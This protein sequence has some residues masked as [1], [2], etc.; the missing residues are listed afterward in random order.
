MMLKP[1]EDQHAVQKRAWSNA[2]PGVTFLSVHWSRLIAGAIFLVTGGLDLFFLGS[3]IGNHTGTGTAI[4]LGGP[5][6]F[7][8]IGMPIMVIGG[9]LV[10]YFLVSPIKYTFTVSA[11]ATGI[12]FQSRSKWLFF[13]GCYDL[14]A[15]SRVLYQR[16]RLGPKSAWIV[17]LVHWIILIL[18]YGAGLFYLP[19]ST[20]QI[21]PTMMMITAVCDAIALAVLIFFMPASLRVFTPGRV[22]DFWISVPPRDDKMQ[23][24][25]LDTAFPA[26]STKSPEKSFSWT[27]LIVGLF[28]IAGSLLGLFA[29]VLLG[30][31]FSMA[32][33]MYGLI[34]VLESVFFDLGHEQQILEHENGLSRFHIKH[35]RNPLSH[36]VDIATPGHEGDRSASTIAPWHYIFIA[37]L[38]GNMAIQLTIALR[39]GAAAN[40][41]SLVDYVVSFAFSTVACIGFGKLLREP[42]KI[43]ILFTAAILT[44]FIIG[45]LF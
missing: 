15:V 4:F 22:H 16:H 19:R 44:G 13:Q 39:F 38:L 29:D 23:R 45:M 24:Y 3:A 43:K 17:V 11:D 36:H 6:F 28:L 7:W 41:L 42:S 18:K 35:W 14:T 20:T 25:L 2:T 31:W 10:V 30:E 12:T 37:F 32:G 34:L 8:L 1:T 5:S 26:N 21:L 27:R 33:L 40:P 9:V